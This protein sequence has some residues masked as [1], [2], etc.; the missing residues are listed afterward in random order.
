MPVNDLP[1][2]KVLYEKED[3]AVLHQRAAAVRIQWLLASR[4]LRVADAFAA[5]DMNHDGALSPSEMYGGLTWLGLHLSPAEISNLIAAFDTDGDGAVSLEEF[6]EALDVPGLMHEEEELEQIPVPAVTSDTMAQ[7][8]PKPVWGEGTEEDQGDG[9]VRV[10]M[11]VLKHLSLRLVPVQLKAGWSSREEKAEGE[12]SVWCP[13]LEF[14]ET[15][16]AALLGNRDQKARVGEYA[17]RGL[18]QPE[19]LLTIEV[20]DRSVMRNSDHLARILPRLLPP[21]LRLRLLLVIG[22]NS[23]SKLHVWEAV[24]PNDDFVALGVVTSSSELPPP[25]SSISCVPKAWCQKLPGSALTRV[26]SDPLTGTTLWRTPRLQLLLASKSPAHPEGELY[27][28]RPEVGQG[29]SSKLLEVDQ[30]S[31]RPMLDSIFRVTT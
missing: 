17:V 11:R 10:P 31:A 28:L 14:Q 7:L 9:R 22:S 2:G 25:L 23:K 15:L 30:Q 24:P 20:R 13:T 29:S 26:W 21:P 27:E 4:G 19:G 8:K 6:R 18:E 16:G 1:V 12:V 3:M 5:F